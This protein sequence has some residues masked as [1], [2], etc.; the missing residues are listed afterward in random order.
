MINH[1]ESMTTDIRNAITL[2]A[3]PNWKTLNKQTSCSHS[4]A[5]FSITEVV[6]PMSFHI[7]YLLNEV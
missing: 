1:I 6:I 5:I 3:K 7:L 2:K 4:Y